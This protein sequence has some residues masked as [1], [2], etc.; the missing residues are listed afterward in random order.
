M[1]SANRI[2]SLDGTTVRLMINGGWSP[3]ADREVVAANFDVLE[4]HGG[5]YDDFCFLA[6]YAKNIRSLYIFDGIWG[7]SKG[8][9]GLSEL[10]EI[11]FGTHIPS[12]DF[13]ILPSL[14]FINIDAW[15]ENYLKSLIKCTK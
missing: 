12:V 14:E 11:S 15:Y 9:D 13:A 4:F 10:R 5:S 1:A 2:K 6:P 3:D 8:L 7:S